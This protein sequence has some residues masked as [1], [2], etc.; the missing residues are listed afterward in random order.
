MLAWMSRDL[1][2]FIVRYVDRRD[3]LQH[4]MICLLDDA[5]DREC[6]TVRYCPGVTRE[7]YASYEYNND[8]ANRPLNDSFTRNRAR[9]L[10]QPSLPRISL[11]YLFRLQRLPHILSYFDL[12]WTPRIGPPQRLWYSQ[13]L[14]HVSFQVPILVPEHFSLLK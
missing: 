4:R 9:F 2:L 10:D 13:I 7:D 14:Q 5:Y 1:L 11:F 3:C 6:H 12:P 8:S